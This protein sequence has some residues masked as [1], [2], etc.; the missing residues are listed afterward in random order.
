MKVLITG[1]NGFI[2]SALAQYLSL[3][4]CVVRRATRGPE[5]DSVAV[6]DIDSS[7]DWAEALARCDAVV[8][9]AA[10][11]HVL[12]DGAADPLAEFRE[13]NAAG[14]L[15]L[16]RQAA[17]AGVRRFVFLS[18]VKV[19]GEGRDEPYR[20]CDPAAPQDP[21][22]MSKWEAEQGLLEIASDTGLQ[23]VILR[24]P[25]VYGP[26]A[27]A[28]FRRLVQMV[29]RGWP[30]PLGAIENRR[31]LLYLGNLVDAIRVCLEHPAAAGRTY[32]LSDGEDVSTPELIRRLARAMGRPA[33]L[34][35][36]P[37]AWLESGARLLGRRAEV[38]RL[39]GSLCVDGGAIREELGWVQPYTLDQGLAETVAGWAGL[40]LGGE[41]GN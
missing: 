34:F 6:G 29:G 4:G 16:A 40:R 14:T 38:G 15:K 30:M 25:L 7:T 26:G 23:V 17:P 27:K 36:V 3:A 18:S 13:V 24:P 9:L 20:T 11:V 41:R 32:L 35:D 33:R 31:S 19:N 12:G 21:Y 2:G 1:A 37:A 22:A 8:H 39:L 28:N 10:R 5:M